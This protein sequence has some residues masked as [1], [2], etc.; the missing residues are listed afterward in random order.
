MA[1]PPLPIMAPSTHDIDGTSST[2]AMNNPDVQ[3]PTSTPTKANAHDDYLASNPHQRVQPLSM[4]THL[5]NP[6]LPSP[7][8]SPSP[9]SSSP[10]LVLTET[11]EGDWDSPLQHSRNGSIFGNGTSRSFETSGPFGQRNGNSPI[12]SGNESLPGPR[13]ISKVLLPHQLSDIKEERVVRRKE[14]KSSVDEQDR[15]RKL[16]L[17]N[18]E[19][20]ETTCLSREDK[21]RRL[22][23]SK[24]DKEEDKVLKLSPKAIQELTSQPDSL[25]LPSIPFVS[26]SDT[27]LVQR[28]TPRLRTRPSF[29][30]KE[31]D[32]HSP[33]PQQPVYAIGSIERPSLPTRGSTTSY[34]GNRDGRRDRGTSSPTR[35]HHHV[36]GDERS[37][38]DSKSSGRP[39]VSRQRSRRPSMPHDLVPP[40]PSLPAQEIPLPPLMSTY[41]QLELAS[42]RPSP[43]YI[44]RS[45]GAD[46]QFES[47]KLKFERL[48]NFLKIPVMLEPALLFGTL[49]CLDAWLYTFTILPLRFIK[50][51]GI[52]VTWWVTSLWREA[53]FVAGFVWNAAPR[54]WQRQRERGRGIPTGSAPP[55]RSTSR[56]VSEN[57]GPVLAPTTPTARTTHRMSDA[58]VNAAL[59]KLA[60]ERGVTRPRAET[61]KRHRRTRS[62]P[63]TLSSYHKADI[64]QGLVIVFSCILLMQL[65]A[66][67]MY[68]SIRGQA[69]MKLYV[70]YNVLEV[71]DH[72]DISS[73][74]QSNANLRATGCR[75]PS[76]CGW[77]RH[78]RVPCLGRDS[79]PGS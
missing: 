51:V 64:L 61:G 9:H 19:R 2:A 79:G 75:S 34:L 28:S 70:I 31:H 4:N 47:A 36:R 46:Y 52:L 39:S 35:H 44:H 69:A 56:A 13:P 32:M 14:R 63:S 18:G 78:L 74:A 5:P 57:H 41:L 50:A 11:T 43:L 73:V 1:L 38:Y 68:H 65:D 37:E 22:S 48:V 3:N 15:P 76:F 21:P 77:S 8:P 33:T 67:R 6:Q 54:I 49:S 25:P 10:S 16:S 17:S 62:I 12:E 30:D 45:R 55:S 23:L 24:D 26:Q 58:G 27:K 20:S 53:R 40:S 60:A 59:E 66:S 42:S 7:S 71:S 72:L 29:N